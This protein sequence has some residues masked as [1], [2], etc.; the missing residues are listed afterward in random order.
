MHMDAPAFTMPDGSD[1]VVLEFFHWVATQPVIDG[2]NVKVSLDGGPFQVI[3]ASA[4]SFNPYNEFLDFSD[5]PMSG[6]EA[7]TGSDPG[8]PT[9]SWA[10]SQIDL[11][12]APEPSS[13]RSAY[14]PRDPMSPW[15][16]WRGT[17][18]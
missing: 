5:N 9:G 8:V 10:V 2:G 1:D 4:F 16:A 7:F 15:V 3:P 13:S 18:M 6:E 12:Q 11:R 14:W 17:S